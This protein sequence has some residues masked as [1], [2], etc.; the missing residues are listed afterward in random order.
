MTPAQAWGPDGPHPC[1]LSVPLPPGSG[2]VPGSLGLVGIVAGVDA[3]LVD[4][5]DIVAGDELVP[6]ILDG[7]EQ[8]STASKSW[9]GG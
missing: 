4:G 1:A 3:P 8:H 5:Q 7:E 2:S 9:T 6:P